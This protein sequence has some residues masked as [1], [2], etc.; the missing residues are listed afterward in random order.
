MTE[1]YRIETKNQNMES[2]VSQLRA[3]KNYPII[4]A[5]YD[6]AMMICNVNEIHSLIQGLEIGWFLAEERIENEDR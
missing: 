6:R 1:L 3:I 5:L 4:I 2:V